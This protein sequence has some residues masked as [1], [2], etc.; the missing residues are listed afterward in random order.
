MIKKLLGF[1]RHQKLSF[2]SVDMGRLV[3]EVTRMFPRLIPES[4]QIRMSANESVGLVRAD[5]GALEQILLN[6]ATNAR[7]AMPEGGTLRIECRRDQLDDGYHATH[8]WVAPGEYV[9]VV[10]S[11]TGIGMDEETKRRVFEPFYTTKPPGEG[12]GLGMAMI[13]GLVKQHGGFVHVYSEPG[14]GTVVKLY[15]PLMDVGAEGETQRPAHQPSLP[16]GT[17]T[18]L[19][20]EDEAAIRRATKRAL[21]RCG[22][23]V[24]L[25]ADGEEALEI[26]GAHASEI[27]LI[28]TDLVMPKLG[29][30]QLHDAL[31]QEGQKTKFLF[32]SGYSAAELAES[33]SVDPV[34]PFLH[35]PW[36][37]NDLIHC[38][39]DVLDKD[40]GGR[41]TG[42][43]AFRIR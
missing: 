38:V 30:R 7:D 12:T 14:Q 25:A 22:Y 34:V 28:M 32:T 5:P 27:D 24:L 35:K 6:L 26:F 42:T 20:V 17:E 33:T 40:A 21:Q 10:V 15:F 41:R 3:A 2:K 29:G 37:V 11:D 36:N 1:S 39:R 23:S 4:M 13:Y 19:V 9:C 43:Q 31:T 16:V 8:P 18:I